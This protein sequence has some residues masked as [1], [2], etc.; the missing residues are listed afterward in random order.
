MANHWGW[1]GLIAKF[2]DHPAWQP[3][4]RLSY[5][6]YITHFF[7]MRYIHNL[8]DRPTHFTSLWRMYIYM[9][10]PTIVVSYVFSFFWS[11]LFEIPVVKLE[12]MLTDGL[13]P[14]KAPTAKSD[15]EEGKRMEPAKIEV[16][17]P[18]REMPESGGRNNRLSGIEEKAEILNK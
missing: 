16:A 9:V 17:E 11:C 3:L 6:G 7:L 5:C 8:D 1:G 14:K 10:I 18:K 13:L 2:M 15:V 12:K 4:G